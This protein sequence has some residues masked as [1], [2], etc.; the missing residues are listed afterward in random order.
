MEAQLNDFVSRLTVKEK[1]SN[2]DIVE[3]LCGYESFVL[4]VINGI[5]K[6]QNIKLY[7]YIIPF[8]ESYQKFMEIDE[9]IARK[10]KY[11][12]IEVYSKL[13]INPNLINS[14]IKTFEKE[15]YFFFPGVSSVHPRS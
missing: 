12:T 4:L 15:R 9:S 3:F 14:F 5:L 11:D 13:S 6:H 10:F 7:R 1:F 8:L 2:R